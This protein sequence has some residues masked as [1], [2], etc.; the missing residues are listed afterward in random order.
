MADETVYFGDPERTRQGG[1]D[2]ASAG[3]RLNTA[4]TK[5]KGT[6]TGLE[7]SAPWGPDEPGKKFANGESG[8]DG[9]VTASTDFL[10]AV[11]DVGTAVEGLGNAVVAAVDQAFGIDVQSATGI[12]GA[13]EA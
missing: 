8:D 3:E 12:D 9:Y 5:H 2:M 7:A 13:T 10:E 4:I 1:K 6:I 11:P